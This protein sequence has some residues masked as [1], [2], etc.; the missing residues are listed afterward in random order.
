[1]IP[2]AQMTKEKINWTSSKLKVSALQRIPSKGWKDNPQTEKI[3][4]NH[5]SEKG[6]VSRIYKEHLQTQQ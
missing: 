2:K 5:I 6:L 1:M 3:F 4:V